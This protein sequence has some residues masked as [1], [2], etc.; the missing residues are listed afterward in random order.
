MQSVENFVET[1]EKVIRVYPINQGLILKNFC[2]D[3][4]GYVLFAPDTKGFPGSVHKS[5]ELCPEDIWA[6]FR[7]R[8]GEGRD[9][10]YVF[11]YIL[12]NS[13]GLGR[14]TQTVLSLVQITLG[15][16]PEGLDFLQC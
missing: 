3:L 2:R 6:I 4:L 13:R 10:Y 12:I 16:S 7:K 8:I 5:S 11:T 1:I 14:L 15:P 9:I